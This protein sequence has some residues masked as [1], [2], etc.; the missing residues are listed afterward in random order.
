M[1]QERNQRGKITVVKKLV[2]IAFFIEFLS[3]FANFIFMMD[4]LP[5]TSPFYL[6]SSDEGLAI[7]TL[8]TALTVTLGLSF[9]FYIFGIEQL[10]FA[11]AYT[12]AAI[13]IYYF[14]SGGHSEIFPFY[15][16]IGGIAAL[17][18]LYI[19]SI[20]LKD[21]YA[22][23]LAMFYSFL[24]LGIVLN[25]VGVEDESIMVVATSLISYGFGIY[26]ATGLFKPFNL[27][28]RKNAAPVAAEPV[29]EV[30]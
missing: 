24:F 4:W 20:R 29:A 28:L 3:G 13:I 8:P 2:L 1:V 18:L 26:Y 17:I 15:I 25:L 16:Y 19:A 30:H 22:L 23:G 11:P 12:M 21:N 27:R 6:S 10:Q 7:N 9:V 14:V 5:T